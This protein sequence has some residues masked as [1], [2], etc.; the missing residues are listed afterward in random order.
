MGWMSS[1]VTRA[2]KK[3]KRSDEHGP[4][5]PRLQ[6]KETKQLACVGLL[7]INTTC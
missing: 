7:S 6:S 1:D 5:V 3:V 4:I 2:D